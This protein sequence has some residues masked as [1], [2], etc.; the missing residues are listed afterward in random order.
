MNILSF[1]DILQNDKGALSPMSLS[2]M[3]KD[4][5]KINNS[6]LFD[7]H[8]EGFKFGINGCWK[9]NFN[10]P[11]YLTDV[12]SESLL[13]IHNYPI[14]QQKLIKAISS[15][16]SNP[17]MLPYIGTSK[18]HAPAKR[19]RAMITSV[20][21]TVL[22]FTCFHTFRV[23]TYSIK[24]FRDITV[25]E[26]AKIAGFTFKDKDGLTKIEPAWLRAYEAFSGAYLFSHQQKKRTQHSTSG[27]SSATKILNKEIFDHIRAILP[28]LMSDSEFKTLGDYAKKRFNKSKPRKIATIISKVKINKDAR[29]IFARNFKRLRKLGFSRI[30]AL[31]ALAALLSHLL[32]PSS[33]SYFGLP[34][35]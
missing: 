7:I 5:I 20:A 1:R 9:S 26:L 31:Y 21:K 24:G 23:G 35:V 6:L 22:A 4:E 19:R 18:N 30:S 11:G 16:F 17:Q 8:D 25:I 32:F 3:S 34:T 28:G 12:R 27:W 33:P 14:Q 29:E 10:I 15:Y 2:C 13:N